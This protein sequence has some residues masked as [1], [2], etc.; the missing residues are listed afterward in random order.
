MKVKLLALI[1]G[2]TIGATAQNVIVE[3]GEAAISL[4]AKE[5]AQLEQLHIQKKTQNLQ[6][7]KTNGMVSQRMSH[8]DVAYSLFSSSIKSVYS[9]FAPDS[10]YIQ[11]FGTPSAVPAHAFGTTFDPASSAFNAIGQD[12]FAQVDPYTIDTVYIGSRYFTSAPVSGLTGDTLKVTLIMGD[13]LDNNV[14]RVGIGWGAGTFPGQTRR[15][16]VIPPRYTGNSNVGTPGTLDAPNQIVMKYALKGSDTANTYKKIIPSSPI[17]V[18]AGKKVG[19]LVEFVPGQPYNPATQTYYRS[20]AK[21]D[22]NSLAYLRLTNSSSSDNTAYFLEPLSLNT[23]SAAISY[24]L[25]SNTRYGA[26]TG[27]D[28][29]RNEYLSPSGTRAYLI[30]FWVSGTSTVG[31][32]DNNTTSK[33]KVY[34]N[35]SSGRVKLQITEGGQYTLSLFDILGKTIHQEQLKLNT[36]EVLSRD[37]SHLPKGIYLV[38]IENGE[39]KSTVKLTLE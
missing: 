13:T 9:P 30:D 10:T 1:T 34:P 22:V 12:Y 20:G 15:I 33:L 39:L 37:F 17:N 8:A 5:Q 4:N 32:T 19:V 7:K 38:N 18:P 24:T 27:S 35:P 16:E 29:F 21:G 36:N 23:T 2:L 3:N 26:W 31:L 11:D 14:W 25:F 28:A 6:R